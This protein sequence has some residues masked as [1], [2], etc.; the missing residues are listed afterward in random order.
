MYRSIAIKKMSKI[1]KLMIIAIAITMSA[2]VNAQVEWGQGGPQQGDMAVGAHFSHYMES[3]LSLSGV[4]AKFRYNIVDLIRLEGTF[5]Y[6]FPKELVNFMGL[7]SAEASMLNFSV[8][9]HRLFPLSDRF[10]LYSLVGLGIANIRTRADVLGIR[11][12]NSESHLVV[13]LGGG[14]DIRITDNFGINLEP[15]LMRIFAED[16]GISIVLSAGV[17]Y[18]F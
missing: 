17:V 14:A 1:K 7:V 4:G 10:T 12:T 2:A 13:N 16:S 6:F 11:A 3:G 5:T 18:N 9:A 15:R 8:N